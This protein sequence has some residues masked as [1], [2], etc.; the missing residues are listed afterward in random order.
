MEN[1][2]RVDIGEKLQRKLGSKDQ[3]EVVKLDNTHVFL[4]DCNGVQPLSFEY[5]TTDNFSR[6][7]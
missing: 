5:F 7:A 6:V 1:I 2:L 4:K 3:V